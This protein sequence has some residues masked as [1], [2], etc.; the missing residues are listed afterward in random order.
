MPLQSCCAH[1]KSR[2]AVALLTTEATTSP[3]CVAWDCPHSWVPSWGQVEASAKSRVVTPCV[4]LSGGW[5]GLFSFLPFLGVTLL[6]C[7]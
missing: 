7:D 3:A 1:S 6:S 4:L 2:S 5:G